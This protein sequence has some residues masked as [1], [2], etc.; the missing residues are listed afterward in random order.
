[1]A[2]DPKQ[3][4]R[5]I[6]SDLS[7]DDR[8]FLDS[9]LRR[10]YSES[11]SYGLKNKYLS[12]DEVTNYQ[13][14]A[15]ERDAALRKVNVT[16]QQGRPISKE[17]TVPV[18]RNG[19]VVQEKRVTPVTPFDLLRKTGGQMDGGPADGPLFTGY[20]LD[21]DSPL[22]ASRKKFQEQII[23]A[24]Q[25][26]AQQLEKTQGVS[27]M[28][29]GKY[30][31]IGAGALAGVPMGAAKDVYAMS[32]RALGEDPMDIA[33]EVYG[34]PQAGLD[35]PFMFG[36]ERS[37]IAG[38][39]FAQSLVPSVLG[40][41]AGILAG[42]AASAVNPLLGLVA[43]VG[44]AMATTAGVSKAQDF[45]LGAAFGDDLYKARQSQ[46]AQQTE[47]NPYGAYAGELATNLVLAGP[48]LPKLGEFMSGAKSAVAAG[49]LARAA[50]PLADMGV[51]IPSPTVPMTQLGQRLSQ[52]AI[53]QAVSRTG[54]AIERSAIGRATNLDVMSAAAKGFVANPEGYR[55]A[56]D[57]A[58]RGI[59]G[60]VDLATALL[61]K[62]R[63]ESEGKE[64]DSYL[65]IFAK[66]LAGSMFEGEHRLG[67][68][69][70]SPFVAGG[71]ALTGAINK[72]FG[73]TGMFPFGPQSSKFTPKQIQQATTPDGQSVEPVQGVATKRIL[74]EN[75]VPMGNGRIGVINRE[76]FTVEPM[77]IADLPDE[78]KD[79]RLAFG[80]FDAAGGKALLDGVSTLKPEENGWFRGLFF[81]PKGME[82]VQNNGQM[83]MLVGATQEGLAITRD[84]SADN[85]IS[86]SVKSMDMLAPE[87]RSRAE[88]I[89]SAGNIQPANVTGYTKSG[90]DGDAIRSLETSGI[91]PKEFSD[92]VYVGNELTPGRIVGTV[93]DRHVAMQIPSPNGGFDF[94]V[95]PVAN[96]ET[97]SRKVREV[98]DYTGATKADPSE[99]Q[100]D[101]KRY[102]PFY[103][104][105]DK[106]SLQGINGPVMLTPDQ[107]AQVESSQ[108]S[109]DDIVKQSQDAGDARDITITKEKSAREN[110]SG[111]LVSNTFAMSEAAFDNGTLIEHVM[112]DGSTATAVVVGDTPVGPLVV[113][114]DNPGQA[115]VV[116]DSAVTRS[117]SPS[118]NRSGAEATTEPTA[119]GDVVAETPV[120]GEVV[121]EA[122]TEVETE[123]ETP[124]PSPSTETVRRRR[125][126]RTREQLDAEKA[127]RER[128][129]A[130]REA[131]LAEEEAA[132]LAEV[133]RLRA[134]A[135]AEARRVEQ[136][137]RRNRRRSESRRT[138]GTTTPTPGVVASSPEFQLSPDVAITSFPEI[139]SPAIV[140]REFNFDP[141]RGIPQVIGHNS[142][143]I[144]V[145]NI[146][147]QEVLFY[148][149]SGENPKVDEATGAVVQPG[150]WYPF[151]GMGPTDGWFN[152]G[153]TADIVRFFGVPELKAG[154]DL[155]NEYYGDLRSLQTDNPDMMS[156]PK[157]ELPHTDGIHIT[158]LNSYNTEVVPG[159]PRRGKY[160][161]ILD[162]I[163]SVSQGVNRDSGPEEHMRN[164][165][166]RF[167]DAFNAYDSRTTTSTETP[168]PE[169]EGTGVDTSVL[170]GIQARIAELEAKILASSEVKPADVTELEALSAEE[171]AAQQQELLNNLHPMDVQF[172]DDRSAVAITGAIEGLGD[173]SEILQKARNREELEAI[174]VDVIK[175]TDRL[176]KSPDKIKR[177]AKAVASFY[178]EMIHAIVN[179][180]LY[181]AQ[182]MMQGQDE[183]YRVQRTRTSS[184]TQ[185]YNE[186]PI[187]D[188]APYARKRV[189]KQRNKIA[190]LMQQ[191]DIPRYKQ[192]IATIEAET[193]KFADVEFSGRLMTFDQLSG[194]DAKKIID[195]VRLNLIRQRYQTNVPVFKVMDA[196]K[197]MN[198]EF[199]DIFYRSGGYGK[200]YDRN[201][202]VGQQIIFAFT[203]ESDISTIV[204]ELSHAIL[205]NMPVEMAGELA[206]HM[207]KTL[208]EP[209]LANPSMIPFEVHEQFAVMMEQSFINGLPINLNTTNG[210]VS[211]GQARINA[212]WNDLSGFMKAAY[213]KT[214][215]HKNARSN[216]DWSA[217]LLEWAVPYIDGDIKNNGKL[218]LWRKLPVVVR[219][220]GTTYRAT[221]TEFTGDAL[222]RDSNIGKKSVTVEFIDAV[223]DTD[224][225]SAGMTGNSLNIAPQDIVAFG[226]IVKGM[227]TQFGSM[228]VK[229]VSGYRGIQDPVTGVSVPVFGLDNSYER[230]SRQLSNQNVPS[231]VAQLDGQDSEELSRMFSR[232]ATYQSASLDAGYR[233]EAFENY[234]RMANAIANKLV[235][236]AKDARLYGLVGDADTAGTL[237]PDNYNN[238]VQVADF[239]RILPDRSKAGEQA[240]IR[241]VGPNGRTYNVTPTTWIQRSI[242][243]VRERAVVAQSNGV[244]DV[245]AQAERQSVAS[246]GGN[247]GGTILSQSRRGGTEQLGRTEQINR[248][249]QNRTP[250][251]VDVE[252]FAHQ[253]TVDGMDRSL[254]TSLVEQRLQIDAL[255]SI[256]Q[257]NLRAMQIN[258]VLIVDGTVD[259][260]TNTSSTVAKTIDFAMRNGIDNVLM[261]TK[262]TPSE[263]LGYSNKGYSVE[264]SVT[265]TLPFAFP[266]SV[267]AEIKSTTPFSRMS[268]DGK[269]VTIH[270]LEQVGQ[271][272]EKSLDNFASTVERIA[273]SLN[274][275]SLPVSAVQNT[276][277]VWNFGSPAGQGYVIP[278]SE[279]RNVLHFLVPESFQKSLDPT[280]DPVVTPTI[281]S[282]LTTL[283]G[284]DVRLPKTFDARSLPENLE[285]RIAFAEN[286]QKLPTNTL[287]GM[288]A[289]ADT[290]K[291]YKALTKELEKQFRYLNMSVSEYGSEDS[292]KVYLNLN[293]EIRTGQWE[294]HPLLKDSPFTTIGGKRLRYADVLNAI[295]GAIQK[296]VSTTTA[297]QHKS[298]L[299]FATHAALTQDPWATWAL[300][301]E[302]VGRETY[303]EMSG[304][305]IRKAGLSALEDV[306]TGIVGIDQR[307]E[308]VR[309]EAK[310]PSGTG[311]SMSRS[312]AM[313]PAQF[314]VGGT[315]MFQSKK[316]ATVNEPL[317]VKAQAEVPTG[318]PLSIS[319]ESFL[320][321]I[322][323]NV[324]EVIA[325]TD[326]TQEIAV[327]QEVIDVM[328]G[329][330][331]GAVNIN[332]V[333]A[334]VGSQD[335]VKLITE[336]VAES[337][338]PD[339]LEQ[340]LYA[341][342][343]HESADLQTDEEGYPLIK[344]EFV[345]QIGQERDVFALA[346]GLS[347]DFQ[348][349]SAVT[350]TDENRRIE[351]QLNRLQNG[352][353][354]FYPNDYFGNWK[355]PLT[356]IDQISQ[357]VNTLSD[358]FY[359]G[360][361]GDNLSQISG[362]LNRAVRM[363]VRINDTNLS[364]NQQ[365]ILDELIDFDGNTND[366]SIPVIASDIKFRI[367]EVLSQ[368]ILNNQF[369]N[370]KYKPFGAS[371]DRLDARDF[372]ELNASSGGEAKKIVDEVVREIT[373]NP[374]PEFKD[375]VKRITG[376]D[377][378]RAN[379]LRGLIQLDTDSVA[380]ITKTLLMSIEN[381]ILR[382]NGNEDGMNYATILAIKKIS[383][384]EPK[385]KIDTPMDK[386]AKYVKE[387]YG[388]ESYSQFR[389]YVINA[390][391]QQGTV[392]GDAV[393]LTDALR[394]IDALHLGNHHRQLESG[395]HEG[396]INDY[397]TPASQIIDTNTN[398]PLIR[399][400]RYNSNG[401][402]KVYHGTGFAGGILSD[403]LVSASVL[404]L[405][406]GIENPGGGGTPDVASVTYMP[407]YAESVTKIVNNI[408]E[409]LLEPET[410]DKWF[411][412]AAE[413]MKSAI[414]NSQKGADPYLDMDAFV[415]SQ[416]F[417]MTN[418]KLGLDKILQDDESR[419]LMADFLG[420]P[421]VL[422]AWV[423]GKSTPTDFSKGNDYLKLEKMAEG[424]FNDPNP[425][426]DFDYDA[427]EKYR[428]LFDKADAI[429]SGGKKTGQ[430][431]WVFDVPGLM[432][433][434]THELLSIMGYWE[435]PEGE[436]AVTTGDI[437]PYDEWVSGMTT[438][439]KS[440]YERFGALQ[441][442]HDVT[443]G[444]ESSDA[445]D[446]GWGYASLSVF[447]KLKQ[448]SLGLPSFLVVKTSLQ[449][450]SELSKADLNKIQPAVLEFELDPDSLVELAFSENELRL[451]SGNALSDVV[452]V[453]DSTGKQVTNNEQVKRI[454]SI[455]ADSSKPFMS[456]ETTNLLQAPPVIAG[457]KKIEPTDFNTYV[458][459]EYADASQ[460]PSSATR[461]T[462]FTRFDDSG[463][464]EGVTARINLSAEPGFPSTGRQAINWSSR[465][466]KAKSADTKSPPPAI[467][468]LKGVKMGIEPSTTIGR[469]A[470]ARS[471]KRT[472]SA[473]AEMI[474]KL[475]KPY[476]FINTIARN[477]VGGDW[478]APL[479]QNWA[480][481]NPFENP[482]M[483]FQQFLIGTKMMK[484]NLGFQLRDGR[485]INSGGMLGRKEFHQL[486]DELRASGFY[487]LGKEAGLVTNTSRVDAAL[488][489]AQKKD[490]R[491]SLMDI[492]ELGHDPDFAIAHSILK[493]VPLNSGAERTMSM[494]KD[495]IKQ[496]KFNAGMRNFM[497]MGYNP[498]AS[499]F[500]D[501]ARDFAAV[502]NV[503]AG[504]T[505]FVN[506]DERD[507]L[508]GR[509]TK[510][511]LF[512][513]RWVTSRVMFDPIARYAVEFL[514]KGK[515][516]LKVNRMLAEGRKLNE[517]AVA[518][519][520]RLW[521]KGYMMWAAIVMLL[522]RFNPF[523][524]HAVEVES[525]KSGTQ[526]RVGDYTFKA[527]G[528]VMFM[529]EMQ[530]MI[531][532]AMDTRPDETREERLDRT[533]DMFKG[534]LMSKIS[535][536]ISLGYEQFTGRDIIGKSSREAY[537]PLQVWWD[538][539]IRPSLK[540]AGIDHEMP[541]WSNMVANRMLYLWAQD[542][543]ETYEATTERNADAPGLEA[544]FTGASAFLGGRVRYAPKE[545]RWMYKA[546]ENATPPGWEYSFIGADP[547]EFF[548][549]L[550]AGD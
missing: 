545:T 336:K 325:Y 174:L 194:N 33:R 459:A 312:D 519:N 234:K 288:N 391:Y 224:K 282:V 146:K 38:Q 144:T 456:E 10:I 34:Q 222:V 424:I 157:E 453:Y 155:L 87:N 98:F 84:L 501:I 31:T 547:D 527:P 240:Y 129:K 62:K 247:T 27:S 220:N 58:E 81:G 485:V 477:S 258:D 373:L 341:V 272:Y 287:T 400:D 178:D 307:L 497:E 50:R 73:T 61:D 296:G 461:V 16:D 457:M 520:R 534:F 363:L 268:T 39:T 105:A 386:K 512:A 137:R 145:L 177:A 198:E 489:E 411:G 30:A 216:T 118:V 443:F 75:M 297:G 482:K 474:D 40:T 161:P 256:G 101:R 355:V 493:R 301:T 387:N 21:L 484:P 460:A 483:F 392:M 232:L 532:S 438:K 8:T 468:K 121:A 150:K 104:G 186:I 333:T 429:A 502:L 93:D 218:A 184:G 436:I 298:N 175:R 397:L 24:A 206:L 236:I 399:P 28:T 166:Q 254:A 19:Q 454:K 473:K 249:N 546:D 492:D 405:K 334:K 227:N 367:Q 434:R 500:K 181:H 191:Q 196:A 80:G 486:G 238:W 491:K 262:A 44:T 455:L 299:S 354:V 423:T 331:A 393:A 305:D 339:D 257:D 469:E 533:V 371:P 406:Q 464:T 504:D 510:R 154:A 67:T 11:L 49:K 195:R 69:V 188:D 361:Y 136:E 518:E 209:S 377:D 389:D 306:K 442:L 349:A 246:S 513:P 122:E 523:N 251:A 308:K 264:P 152:K 205:D 375:A 210:R 352:R 265:F 131:K 517:Y 329:N 74:P 25:K 1:M 271:S 284:Q 302:T 269:S 143:F 267:Y 543:L 366:A 102:N 89:F 346:A 332:E 248:S 280:V 242:R 444:E 323:S 496:T 315:L 110:A 548:K 344:P 376:R 430:R 26:Q 68:K 255:Q 340:A 70:M 385:L 127:E 203:G 23:P 153:R 369:E 439:L 381:H 529:L 119:E 447:P 338:Q 515:E 451:F 345:A 187:P 421:E 37:A 159:N 404:R 536:A 215:G 350:S 32:R 320:D 309:R 133:E 277:R 342:L 463:V 42:G 318:A 43:G 46:I 226:G 57:I 330:L 450:W 403:K 538:N 56:T 78:F 395:D 252:T 170:D 172:T 327:N 126:R 479:I 487:Q 276:Q 412:S 12:T 380:E 225:E 212:I 528:G 192:I 204:H 214:Y 202:N 165:L 281:E 539:A 522:T 311:N 4:F 151:F 229:W 343:Q 462:P 420:R 382:F 9:G 76:N 77:N 374:Y 245:L 64:S 160:R 544:A 263:P 322:D 328:T 106:I 217:N 185:A 66:T 91:N 398:K 59:E 96:L 5:R 228:L 173:I 48:S 270:N 449:R 135:E 410:V 51:N 531:S 351:E 507:E 324:A 189:L 88:A 433:A 109:I 359:E 435:S 413:R 541:K 516:W 360:N 440:D 437:I 470:E 182:L 134:E 200:L 3:R 478:S 54:Q 275:R 163:N 193:T 45:L 414:L 422:Y 139:T 120:E 475:L 41:G 244:L 384:F 148:L 448:S 388:F 20:T 190:R 243:F 260:S 197:G 481:T 17:T 509:M 113:N 499:G 402:I 357:M 71:E 432:R 471:V 169:P 83:E 107:M 283:R 445:P 488:A 526:L 60:S 356:A 167:R 409:V 495:Y 416:N 123:A 316:R 261:L 35:N 337:S 140:N 383:E 408:R 99:V 15:R 490:P 115:Y 273:N 223:S 353:T 417:M 537:T 368:T 128:K 274:K 335:F 294:D 521:A 514:P 36:A 114:V 52:G 250:E 278:F 370:G 390:I 7:S 364:P 431:S 511:I 428:K 506:D 467:K 85:Q 289:D 2:E 138:T 235:R 18:M 72:Q 317:V 130:E 542:A 279:A 124:T 418:K 201:T 480:L 176:L 233:G 452:A 466:K 183:F 472:P 63:Q 112:P 179:R 310:Y 300:W 117:S 425:D 524:E 149:S 158:E 94:I 111:A 319:G 313:S 419:K 141:I 295:H 219:V 253:A 348:T 13:G 290:V 365:S 82:G 108:T 47:E 231:F 156:T 292:A 321:P 407:V 259:A 55:F 362:R 213:A 79:L 95:T 494:Q 378:I 372:D 550:P 211:T 326:G 230:A 65:A 549:A 285:R 92:E 132:R 304:A 168:T 125:P 358:S 525:S 347:P 171:E 505:K 208:R 180:D 239:I 427:Y 441:E 237:Q 266:E 476:D 394:K 293:N 508:I 53:G 465:R 530:A 303:K 22:G 503:A 103:N 14:L 29:A 86:V 6:L 535:P 147:G 164:E 426:P 199:D 116:Q 540:E 396:Y 401:T 446:G 90:Y 291:A 207:G 100:I 498:K 97:R 286:Y 314:A 415:M 142:R 221:V 162:R 241:Q 458:Q 379:E